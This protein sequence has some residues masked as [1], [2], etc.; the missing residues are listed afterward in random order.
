[1]TLHHFTAS[2]SCNL[3]TLSHTQACF[4]FWY[5]HTGHTRCQLI[6]T[7][8][9]FAFLYP[10]CSEFWY[11]I[12]PLLW[13]MPA[14]QGWLFVDI[15]CLFSFVT[16]LVIWHRRRMNSL[17][18]VVLWCRLRLSFFVDSRKLLLGACIELCPW[19]SRLS[20]FLYAEAWD[21][22]VG[23]HKQGHFI[24]YLPTGLFTVSLSESG[25]IKMLKINKNICLIR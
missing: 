25:V 8:S 21:C 2:L 24:D 5:S 17:L 22:H 3:I 20:W 15:R 4:V 9:L 13:I 19:V 7:K 23:Y 11:K 10:D 6:S 14:P 18:S 12:N 16:D 1:M